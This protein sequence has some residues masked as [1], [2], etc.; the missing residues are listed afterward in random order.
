MFARIKARLAVYLGC[1]RSPFARD[2]V[3]AAAD[4]A[5][6]AARKAHRSTRLHQAAKTERLHQMLGGAR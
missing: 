5:E 4:A 6:K 3:W 1:S 2:P